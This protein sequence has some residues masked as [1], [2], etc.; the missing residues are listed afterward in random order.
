ML[1]SCLLAIIICKAQSNK[2]LLIRLCENKH[3][4]GDVIHNQHA[5]FDLKR[6]FKATV[7]SVEYN[8]SN[9]NLLKRN[10]KLYLVSVGNSISGMIIIALPAYVDSIPKRQFSLQEKQ[11]HACHSKIN[12]TLCEFSFD[13]I[14]NIIGSKAMQG[15]GKNEDCTHKVFQTIPQSIKNMFV[16]KKP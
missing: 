5:V 7:D 16:N 2:P 1:F 9:P 8:F 3:V 12:R 13:E 14:G 11:M 4:I 15:F 10:S 6:H